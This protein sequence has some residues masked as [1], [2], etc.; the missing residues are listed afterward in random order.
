MF[1]L[2]LSP[3]SWL[4]CS[5]GPWLLPTFSQ[6]LLLM[7][8]PGMLPR[9]RL[10]PRPGPLLRPRLCR[11]PG[12]HRDPTERGTLHSPRR[13]GPAAPHLK[14][15][16]APGELTCQASWARWGDVLSHRLDPSARTPAA[17]TAVSTP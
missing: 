12:G 8:T 9:R 3:A 7:P 1:A 4:P 10:E 13:E 5:S 16:L 11:L 17:T 6:H 14:R 15:T 2:L